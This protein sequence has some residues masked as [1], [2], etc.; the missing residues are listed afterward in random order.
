MILSKTRR[1]K[2]IVTSSYFDDI[3]TLRKS[4][5]ETDYR[6]LYRNSN[7]DISKLKGAYAIQEIILWRKGCWE[8]SDYVTKLGN[9]QLENLQTEYFGSDYTEYTDPIIEGPSD[10]LIADPDND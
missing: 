5:Y 8:L 1:N 4:R 3:K 10:R 7:F 6:D 2:K 9:H